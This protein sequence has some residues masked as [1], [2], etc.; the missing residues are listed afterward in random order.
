MLVISKLQIDDPLPEADLTIPEEVRAKFNP[1]APARNADTIPLGLAGQPAKEIAPGIVFIPGLW[2]VTLVHQD[3]GIVILEAP[4]SSGYSAKVIADAHRRF[5]GQPIKAV[6]TT[7][8]SWPHLAGIREYV[9]QGIPIYALDLNRPVLERVIAMPYTSRPDAQ[10]HSS[11]KPNFH[12]VHGKTTLGAGKNRMEI[13]PIHG[14]TSERQMMVYFP[15]YHLLYGSD[16]FQ[17]NEDGSFFYPQTVTELMDAVAREHLDV[18]QF[19]MMHIGPTPW[20][21]LEK[22]VKAAEA[23]DTPNGVL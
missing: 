21:D 18:H 15:E 20:P 17:Q 14:E 4:I 5:P 19:F 3:D 8:D 2:N 12:L 6:I 11:R 7:S 9:A 22:A 13:Y 23:K 16:P 1:N 10:Q